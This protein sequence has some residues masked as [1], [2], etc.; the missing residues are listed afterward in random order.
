MGRGS[1][2]QQTRGE[3]SVIGGGLLQQLILQIYVDIEYFGH[4]GAN[5]CGENPGH[6]SYCSVPQK[7]I[8]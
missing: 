8:G 5:A 6:G 1:S 3:G 4:L 2:E 7:A